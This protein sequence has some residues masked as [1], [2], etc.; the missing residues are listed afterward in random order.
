[1]DLIWKTQKYL[2]SADDNN[3]LFFTS[4]TC[5]WK[6]LLLRKMN[7]NI[8]LTIYRF[9]THGLILNRK[10]SY[11]IWVCCFS[12]CSYHV[13]FRHLQTQ[14]LFEL[15][16]SNNVVHLHTCADSCAALVNVLQYL[17]A[18]GDLHPPLRHASPTEIAGQKLPV[19][20][21]FALDSN[22][23]MHTNLKWILCSTIV[24]CASTQKAV[25]HESSDTT[26]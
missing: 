10:K 4:V 15:R 1:M 20:T 13:T 18:Q 9:M 21:V 17:V 16:C 6:I 23:W 8:R 2:T 11:W 14:P 7:A 24:L 26:Q 12:S 22:W 3:W 25:C 19:R 5:N